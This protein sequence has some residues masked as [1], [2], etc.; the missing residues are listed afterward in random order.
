MNKIL[1]YLITAT[2]VTAAAVCFVLFEILH[3]RIVEDPITNTLLTSVIYHLALCAMLFWFIFY[4]S[5]LPLFSF[6]NLTIKKLL[7]CLPCLLV[8]LV[9]F[10]YS[11]LIKGTVQFARADLLWLYIIYVILIAVLEEVVFR[12]IFIFWL[13]DVFRNSKIRNFLVVLISSAVF[14]LFHLFNLIGGMSVSDVLLQVLYTFLIGA[15]LAVVVLKTKN[16]LI[17]IVIHALFDFGGLLTAGIA[18]G[19]PWDVVFWILTISCGILCA[20]HI[21][22][23]LINLDRKDVS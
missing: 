9:N 3:I 21:I 4:L 20:G 19:N 2:L 1:R 6:R 10:P 15:M 14:A 23:S 18:I 11:G 22:V 7:W 5:P 8:A 13:K 16:V 12:G 17:P